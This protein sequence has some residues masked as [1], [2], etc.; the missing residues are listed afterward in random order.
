MRGKA[1]YPRTY[2]LVQ[3]AELAIRPKH[4]LPQ[5]LWP[6]CPLTSIPVYKTEAL[7]SK[8]GAA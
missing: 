7:H 4:A 8:P 1:L 5:R 3:M 2:G 6:F